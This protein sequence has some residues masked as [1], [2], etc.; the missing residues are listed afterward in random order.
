MGIETW[1]ELSI[2]QLAWLFFQSWFK[3]KVG[4]RRFAFNRGAFWFAKSLGPEF[5]QAG[6][7]IPYQWKQPAGHKIAPKRPNFNAAV[8]YALGRLSSELSTNL[9]YHNL[10]HTRED[11]LAGVTRLANR[12]GLLAEQ[13]HLMEVAAAFHDLGFIQQYKGHEQVSAEL[14]AHFLPDFGLASNQVQAVVG[15]IMATRLPQSPHNLLEQI[16]A[17]ADMDVLG[18]PDFWIRNQALRAEVAVY[19][20]PTSERAWYSQQLQFLKSHVY[21]TGVAE[22]LRGLGKRQNIAKI[23][24]YLMT[25]TDP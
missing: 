9:T 15:M 16:V 3:S 6:G 25:L 4:G 11:V 2:S 1:D 7:N 13:K 12:L 18:R 19:G 21:F 24:A 22:Q 8:A 17:D 20:H 23:E 10:R 14:A 5:G